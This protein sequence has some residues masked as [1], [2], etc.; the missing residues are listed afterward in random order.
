MTFCFRLRAR[1]PFIDR[2]AGGMVRPS[3]SSYR[4]LL[5]GLAP[6]LIPLHLHDGPDFQQQRG[7]N[8]FRLQSYRFFT[9]GKIFPAS[10][11]CLFA[12]HRISAHRRPPR[13]SGSQVTISSSGTEFKTWI[14][15]TNRDL[16]SLLSVSIRSER[17]GMKRSSEKAR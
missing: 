7:K 17:S 8:I 10:R 15:E 4:R 2:R 3:T 12:S 5:F 13:Y 6:H 9:V 16:D 14:H 1:R 11:Q